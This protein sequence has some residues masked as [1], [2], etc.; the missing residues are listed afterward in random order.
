VPADA[1]RSITNPKLPL[2]I[3]VSTDQGGGTLSGTLSIVWCRTDEQGV[4]LLDRV[5]LDLPYTV[6]PGGL[7]VAPISYTVELAR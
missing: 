1:S 3:P 5:R 4:C 7:G 6:A 2:D